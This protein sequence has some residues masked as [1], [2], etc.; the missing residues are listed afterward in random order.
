MTSKPLLDPLEM[1]HKALAQWETTVNDLSNRGTRNEHYNR[2]M[3]KASTVALEA[4]QKFDAANNRLLDPMNLPSRQQVD[5]LAG[6]L[7]RIEEMLALLLERTGGL[8]AAN[9]SAPDT[10][11]PPRTR[12]PPPR[13]TAVVAPKTAAA[14]PRAKSA[15]RSRKAA[16]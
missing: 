6:R 5:E 11:R 12:K 1:W 15:S 16:S 9:A 3:Q 14:A 10:A 2:A 13:E 8:P 4:Q 7:L